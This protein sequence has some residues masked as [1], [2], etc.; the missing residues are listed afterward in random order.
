MLKQFNEPQNTAELKANLQK[1]SEIC[2][3]KKQKIDLLNTRL[4]K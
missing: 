2:L 3:I 1:I 4:T